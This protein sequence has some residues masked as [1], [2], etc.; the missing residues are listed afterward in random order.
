MSTEHIWIVV[1]S[2]NGLED[3]R[4]CLTS[5]A[6]VTEPGVTRLLVD[7]GSTDG[8]AAIVSEEFPWCRVLTVTENR[9]PA[10]GYN[11]GIRTALAGGADGVLLLNNDTVVAPELV[12]RLRQA[13]SAHPEYSIIGPVIKFM[14]DPEQ[15]MIDGFTFNSPELYGFFH[16]KVVAVTE[17]HPPQMTAVDAVNGC[18]VLI[19]SAVFER[20]GLFDETI[21][22]YHDETDFCLRALEAGF[23]AGVIDHA[24]VWHKGSATFKTSG[25]R[26]ARY[27]D[28]R[29]L[30]YVLR[31]HRGAQRNGRGRFAS[32]LMYARYMYHWYCTE[33]EAGYDQ[34]ADAVIEGVWDGMLGRMGRY[35][36]GRRMATRPVRA[37]LEVL[38]RLPRGGAAAVAGHG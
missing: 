17:N 28:A 31:K 36:D 12:T 8:T 15:V 23:K 5:L 19:R 25:K 33:R 7:N 32:A 37:I 21:F 11:A 38:R 26:L 4:K 16:R 27:Y 1:L 35:K 22:I 3:T 6:A 13:A 14:D 18:C 10:A 20:I 24:L 2:Y 34:S 9:G 29:N 30:L